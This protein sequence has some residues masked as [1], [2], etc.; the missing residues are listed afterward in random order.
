MGD[1]AGADHG[2]TDGR[3]DAFSRSDRP[4]LRQCGGDSA[5]RLRAAPG[6]CRARDGQLLGPRMFARCCYGD[7]EFGQVSAAQ[8]APR[9]Q[10][11]REPRIL[12]RPCNSDSGRHGLLQ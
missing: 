2:S 11:F 10:H 6:T 9:A 3:R 8:V 7:G 5:P 12:N 4:G 1:G